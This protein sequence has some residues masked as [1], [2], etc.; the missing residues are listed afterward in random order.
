MSFLPVLIDIPLGS[1]ELKLFLTSIKGWPAKLIINFSVDTFLYP[2]KDLDLLQIL[3][4]I[5]NLYN[6]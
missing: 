5:N 3:S 2:I 6:E 1:K 4:V